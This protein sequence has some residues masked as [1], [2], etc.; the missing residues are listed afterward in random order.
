MIFTVF[1]FFLIIDLSV[2]IPGTQ[3]DFISSSFFFL[4]SSVLTDVVGSSPSLA[5]YVLLLLAASLA[6]YVPPFIALPCLILVYLWPQEAKDCGG[7]GVHRS[8]SVS[9][10]GLSPS[11]VTCYHHTVNPWRAETA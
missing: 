8:L 4:L 3:L 1:F 10:Q 9:L 6:F 2:C 11:P 7:P 5:A